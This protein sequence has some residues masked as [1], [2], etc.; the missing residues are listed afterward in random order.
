MLMKIKKK[1]R[2]STT[3]FNCGKH[4]FFFLQKS[5]NST[6]LKAKILHQFNAQGLLRICLYPKKTLEDG[7]D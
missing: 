3:R 5:I 2:S 6:Y 7:D 1:N 4:F